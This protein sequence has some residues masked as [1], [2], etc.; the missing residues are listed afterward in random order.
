MQMDNPSSGSGDAGSCPA[1]AS[2][3]GCRHSSCLSASLAHLLLLTSSLLLGKWKHFFGFNL[4]CTR[5]SITEWTCLVSSGVASTF[6]EKAIA[7]SLNW[8]G[9]SKK[10]HARHSCPHGVV[11]TGG[12]LPQHHRHG[13]GGRYWPS[14]P[15]KP[16]QEAAKHNNSACAEEG[17]K[18]AGTEHQ[19]HGHCIQFSSKPS[20]LYGG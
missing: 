5:S 16:L 8:G 19:K 17:R 7:I 12:C 9:K 20:H 3:A 15:L 1:G 11:V 13:T 18:Q 2:L 10:R 14:A 6:A 4:H